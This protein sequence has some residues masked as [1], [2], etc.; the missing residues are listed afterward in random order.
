V[1][2]EGVRD[3]LGEN[4]VGIYLHGSAVLG[5]LR[6]RSDLD[7]I[8]VVAK[9]LTNDEKQRLAGVLAGISNKPRPL[10]F[11]LVVQAEVRPWRYPPT[12]DF[13]YSEWWPGVRD[14]DTN[15]DLAV[16]ITMLLA[17]DTPLYGPP[18]AT[19]FEAV[20]AADF[21]RATLAAVGDV[22]RRLDGDTRNVLLTLARIWASIETGRML[23]KDGAATWALE[24]L[25][26]EHK[27]VLERARD[28]YL[29]GSRGSWDDLREEVRACADYTSKAIKTASTY[30]SPRR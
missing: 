18:P 14:R 24:R 30:S 3:V 8:T 26:E 22:I 23:S 27:P 6:K 11:D 21:R 25:P 1:L 9:P 10:D 28:L 16:L 17:G 13:H 4:V 19:V 5:G 29:E 15:V 12:F 2:I 20:P 7:V